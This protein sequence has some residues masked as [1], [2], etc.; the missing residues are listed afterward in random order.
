M[1]EARQ[2]P[3]QGTILDWVQRAAAT[4]EAAGLYFGH[5]T[6]NAFDEACWMV[7]YVLKLRPDFD[8]ASM[9]LKP[10]PAAIAELNQL[11]DQRIASRKP[12]AYLIGEAWFAGLRFDVDEHTLV[13]RSPLAELIAGGLDP[14]LDL[15]QPLQVLDMGTGSGCIAVALARHWPKLDI[16]AVDISEHAL[17]VAERNIQ[18]LGVADRVHARRSDL[19]AA[20]ENK[21]YD[22]IISNPPYVPEA[23]MQ[24]LPDEYRHEPAMA[25]AAGRDGL[26]IVRRLL[27][28]A[29]DYLAPHGVLVVE[30]G[31]ASAA[32]GR[33]LADTEAVWLEF[34]HGGE[35]VF[36][37]DR[38]ACL[39]FKA[40]AVASY[41]NQSKKS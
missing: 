30:V 11:L 32:A 4:M 31:E 41:S 37:I 28:R 40:Q 13:P 21:R 3:A 23:S 38:A 29:P 6:A 34:E 2:M 18:R 27:S 1:Q 26:D 12:L 33:L 39:R 35:G 36:L 19:F 7:T 16:D 14:W 25:L 17:D 9:Q 22:L 24:R 20:L 10:R 5:G 15:D 8:A